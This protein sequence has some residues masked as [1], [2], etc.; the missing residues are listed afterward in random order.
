[1][2]EQEKLIEL[3]N[4][5]ESILKMAIDKGGFRYKMPD[6]GQEAINAG[7]VCQSDPTWMMSD[8]YRASNGFSLTDRGLNAVLAKGMVCKCH[9]CTLVSQNIGKPRTPPPAISAQ[10]ARVACAHSASRNTKAWI[11]ADYIT[12]TSSKT[13]KQNLKPT[14]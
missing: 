4:T 1:M 2:I 13:P 6:G 7:L 5:H 9:G 10:Y 8:D 3:A 11:A 12:C 14:R